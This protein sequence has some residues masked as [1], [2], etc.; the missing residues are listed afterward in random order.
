M[1]DANLYNLT[2]SLAGALGV[3]MGIIRAQEE[4]QPLPDLYKLRAGYAESPGWYMVQAL[5]FDPG[6]LTVARLRVRDIYAAE[7]LVRGLLEIMASEKW[8]HR[9]GENYFLSKLGRDLQETRRGRLT[10]WLSALMPLP[11]ADMKRLEQLMAAIINASLRSPDPPG[12]WCLAHSRN[13]APAN[14]APPAVKI[15]Q[16]TADFNAFRDDAH[17]AAWGPL[18]V[19][20]RTWEAFSFLLTQ[21]AN[22]A[23]ALFDQLAYRGYSQEDYAAALQ[24][25]AERGWLT[26]K[27]QQ[28]NSYETTY[29]VTTAGR[30]VHKQ[31]EA[32]TDEYFFNPWQ[33]LSQEELEDLIQLMEQ[34]RDA[35]QAMSR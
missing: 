29:Q 5:E 3:G 2:Q 30:E 9:Q 34:A 15:F 32:L 27:Q 20:G 33:T 12:T 6:P 11:V 10:R 21:S 35:L 7:S 17:M 26:V 22:S 19:D 13:R 31:I 28:A 14:D 18:G 8:L 25:L 16:F 4:L 23:A 1:F 24:N